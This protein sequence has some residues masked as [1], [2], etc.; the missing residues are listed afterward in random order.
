MSS[1]VTVVFEAL[2]GLVVKKGRDKAADKLKDGG[3]TDPKFR[4][5]IVRE[6]D[7][8]KSKLEGL[9]R[10]DL[11]ASIS[12]FE[13]GIELLYE[14]F[15]KARSRTEYG[16]V[17]TQAACAEAFSVSEEIR[18]LELTDLDESA[19][20]VLSK[21]K[22]R[23]E[24]SRWKAT[25]AF[26]N[27]ALETSDRILAMR[28]RV[29]ATILE[30]V[31]HPVDAIAPCRVCIKELNSLLAVQNSFDAQFNCKKGIRAAV[32]GFFG[33]DERRKVITSVCH[34]NR[35]IYDVTQAVGIEV[36]FWSWP[37]VGTEEGGVDPLRDGRVTE[38]F[39]KQ[40]MDDC[41]VTWTFGQEGEEEHKLKKPVGI[42][43]NSSGQFI[44]ADQGESN[45]KVFDSTGTFVN[46]LSLPSDDKGVNAAT[47][48]GSLN[49]KE[50][51]LRELHFT[52]QVN[53]SSSLVK[54]E[55]KICC[56]WEYTPKMAS[57]CRALKSMMNGLVA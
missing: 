33:R 32:W 38:V 53:M 47:F 17:T 25:E 29:M 1:I 36:P 26:K 22:K 44:V 18:N 45:V 8:I 50:D 23:F 20:R 28:Y 2:I 3:V 57:L 54:N 40:D 10:K 31:D 19:S 35:V 41:R 42:A 6:I 30:T 7:D 49:S 34:L 51:M 27:D 15:D 56:M 48:S 9:S 43:T 11:L 46:L 24:G 21:A 16:A 12:F 13:E 4:R 39:Q 5:L 55:R 14:V 52:G 37:T